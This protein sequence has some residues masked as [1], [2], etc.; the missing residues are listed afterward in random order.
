MPAGL[1]LGGVT[2]TGASAGDAAW[3][4][5]AGEEGVGAATAS[6]SAEAAGRRY[7]GGKADFIG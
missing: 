1:L 4:G 3:A 6:T 2:G 7:P 5:A